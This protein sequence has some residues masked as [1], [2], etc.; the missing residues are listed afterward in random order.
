[1]KVLVAG[2]AVWGVVLSA[3]TCAY[4]QGPKIPCQVLRNIDKVFVVVGRL[5][6]EIERDGLY[7]STLQKDVE[8][9]LSMAGVRVLSDEEAI[10][11]LSVPCLNLD[12]NAFKYADG[13][14]YSIELYLRDRVELLRGHTQ[15]TATIWSAPDSVGITPHLSEIREEAEDMVGKFIEA[16]EKV[17]ARRTKE[18]SHR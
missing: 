16:W 1:M 14:V 11:G 10:D 12:V 2:L 13:Y 15:I 8:F 5:K 7:G 4:A 9:R 3:S 18:D 6:P 17:N